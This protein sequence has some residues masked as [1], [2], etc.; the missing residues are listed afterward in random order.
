M[1]KGVPRLIAFTLQVLAGLGPKKLKPHILNSNSVYVNT[2]TRIATVYLLR[3]C[4]YESR[5]G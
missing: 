4:M 2:R 3:T 1:Q 5:I